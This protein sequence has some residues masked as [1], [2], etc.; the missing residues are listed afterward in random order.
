MSQLQ[1]PCRIC[2]TRFTAEQVKV[3]FRGY[4]QGMLASAEAKEMPG[5]ATPADQ[6]LYHLTGHGFLRRRPLNPLPGSM[7]TLLSPKLGCHHTRQHG[8]SSPGQVL[9]H[10]Q[11]E[12]AS[13]PSIPRCAQA[14]SRKR[15]KVLVVAHRHRPDHM[16]ESPRNLAREITSSAPS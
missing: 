4:C 13:G 1:R 12:D 3:L 6:C 5:I 11:Q 10:Q 14:S 2:D 9:P 8:D 7:R 15:V 16:T